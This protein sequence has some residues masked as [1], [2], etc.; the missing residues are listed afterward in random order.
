MTCTKMT[1]HTIN[2]AKAH[3]RACKASNSRNKSEKNLD[4][5]R[6]YKCPRCQNY[7]LTTQSK[8]ESKRIKKQY[9]KKRK[10]MQG[11]TKPH[12]I[13]GTVYNQ[14]AS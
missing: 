3:I 2:D 7:H 5:I 8:A 14:D 12:P 1:F 4:N 9:R 11:Q 6:P 10:E 13:Y